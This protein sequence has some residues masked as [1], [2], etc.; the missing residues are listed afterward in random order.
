MAPC[1]KCSAHLEVPE[2]WY[3]DQWECVNEGDLLQNKRQRAYRLQ[4]NKGTLIASGTAIKHEAETDKNR[5]RF[6]YSNIYCFFSFRSAIMGMM[7]KAS[8]I[9]HKCLM[10]V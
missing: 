8:Q 9:E 10:S 1:L 2:T 6:H 7:M 3:E 4:P 5:F